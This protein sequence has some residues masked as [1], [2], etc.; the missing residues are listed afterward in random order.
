MAV[1]SYCWFRLFRKILK[2]PFQEE[3][4]SEM[5]YGRVFQILFK[6]KYVYRGLNI[7]VDCINHTMQILIFL[8]L[9]STFT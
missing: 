1:I 6:K 3:Q 8:S 9:T 7:K 2:N 4:I 5:C